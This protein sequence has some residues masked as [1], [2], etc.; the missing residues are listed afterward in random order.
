MRGHHPAF[1]PLEDRGR[2]N[3]LLDSLGVSFS[4]EPSRAGGEISVGGRWWPVPYL[5][6]LEKCSELFFRELE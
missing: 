6:C 4:F 3:E 1:G 5:D 2:C